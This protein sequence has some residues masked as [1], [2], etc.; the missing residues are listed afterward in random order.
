MSHYFP[1]RLVCILSPIS[2]KVYHV[3]VQLLQ[4]VKPDKVDKEKEDMQVDDDLLEIIPPH[5]IPFWKWETK[6][7]L[8]VEENLGV[9][10]QKNDLNFFFTV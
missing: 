9:T 7:R 8:G 6:C 5:D 1:P 3:G 4:V 10:S 2:K